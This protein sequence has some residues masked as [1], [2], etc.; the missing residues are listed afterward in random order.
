MKRLVQCAAIAALSCASA[1]AEAQSLELEGAFLG[2]GANVGPG[3]RLGVVLSDRLS[4]GAGV[5]AFLYSSDTSSSGVGSLGGLAG[6]GSGLVEVYWIA[7]PVD[8]KIWVIPASAGA[9]SPTIRLVGTYARQ[10]SGN[11]GE[12]SSYGGGVLAGA[13]Y[14]LDEVIGISLEAG[15][16]YARIFHQSDG[17]EWE[18]ESL[19]IGYRASLVLRI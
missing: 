19:S 14:M 17:Y 18:E 12:T 4:L 1:P 5:S 11:I 10:W 2:S 16:E 3:F 13:A 7:L 9:V 8:L 6:G 15:V